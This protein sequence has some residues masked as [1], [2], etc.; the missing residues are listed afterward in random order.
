MRPGIV[1]EAGGHEQVAP[2]L[3]RHLHRSAKFAEIALAQ[4]ERGKAVSL[5]PA[6]IKFFQKR[7]VVTALLSQ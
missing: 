5:Q 4:F 6:L 3:L 2:I 7:K 1:A